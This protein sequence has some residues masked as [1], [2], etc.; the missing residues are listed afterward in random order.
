[1]QKLVFVVDDNDSNLTMA[2]SVLETEYRV[3]TMPS[4]EKMFSLLKKKRPDLIL[5]DVEMPEMSG[6]EAMKLLKANEAY[7]DIPVIFLTGL[8]DSVNEAHGIELG[9]VDF[10]TKPFSIPVLMKRIKNHLDIDELIRERTAQL[11]HLK[12]GVVFILADIV[13]SRDQNTGGHIDRTSIYTEILINAMIEHGV[14]ADEIKDW[15][16]ESVIS[17]AR[18]HDVGKISISDFILNKPGKLTDEEFEIMKTHASIGGEI[19]DRA[20]ARTGDAEFLYSAKLFAAYH[21][22]KWDGR[23]YS[24]GLKG[25]EI[26]LHGR[27]M[28]VIDVYD[29]LVSERPYKKAFSHEKAVSI[30]MEDAGTHFDPL[31]AEVFCKV[32]EKIRQAALN[33]VH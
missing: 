29:A 21:H 32:N 17:S 26:P 20:I 30:I 24:L 15:D 16:L 9:A 5:L 22:E 11:V 14:Y 13:E 2:A 10:I 28:A 6:F 23:G 1:M 3:L 12:N 4:A 31:I 19:I 7:A 8:T 25:E 27:I 18:L 33:H